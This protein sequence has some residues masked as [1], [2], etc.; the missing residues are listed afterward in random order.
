M[1]TP[2]GGGYGKLDDTGDAIKKSTGTNT[3]FLER[4]SVFDYRQS[5]ESA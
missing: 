5:Q 1:K 2:G 4:G 3:K